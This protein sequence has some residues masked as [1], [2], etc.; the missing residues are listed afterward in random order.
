MTIRHLRIFIAVV[1]TG[2]MRLAAEKLYISQPAI[3]QA[4][5]ELENY[6]NVKLFERLGQ[7]LYLTE[8]GKKLLNHARHLVDS[9]DR[10]DLM[11]KHESACPKLRVG[12]SVSVGTYLVNQIFAK[13]DQVAPELDFQVVVDNTS[14]IE[15]MLKSSQLD[16]GIVEGVIT[17]NEFVIESIGTDELVV[18]VGKP[19]PLYNV[20]SVSFKD[21]ENQVW[22]GREAG[23]SN[24]NQ[25]EQLLLKAYPNLVHKWRCTNTES[26]KQVVICGRGIAIMSNMLIQKELK[27][28]SLRVLK[29]RDVKVE[30]DIKLVYHK[31]KYISPHLEAF[32]KICKGTYE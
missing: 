30:R 2:K 7:K 25:Y 26:I 17:N 3:S 21:L 5:Q 32:I 23:S 13:A 28:G 18:I 12:T 19:H 14:K 6:Y 10:L 22:I 24:R 20:E 15:E 11:M 9:F 1:E 8:S 27:E 29:V 4:I 16:I 31:N